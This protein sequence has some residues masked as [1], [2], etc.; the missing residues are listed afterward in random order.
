M[1]SPEQVEPG[2]DSIVLTG[3][4]AHALAAQVRAL[5]GDPSAR[6]IALVPGGLMVYLAHGPTRDDQLREI[7]DTLADVR[8]LLTDGKP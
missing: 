5:G 4:A 3:P 2:H 8:R 6:R 1:G 7:R